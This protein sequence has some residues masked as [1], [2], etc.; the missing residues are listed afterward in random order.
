MN[1]GNRP[2]FDGTETTLEVNIFGFSGD[3]YG[4]EVSVKFVKRLRGER[5]F[6]SAAKLAEQLEADRA[7]A[8]AA[9]EA[10]GRQL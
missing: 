4:H 10:S 1:I 5:K 7:D 9:L 8:M 6:S 2:T 3:L